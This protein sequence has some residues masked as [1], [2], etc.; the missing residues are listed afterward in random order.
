[1]TYIRK[2]DYEGAKVSIWIVKNT[3][4]SILYSSTGGGG[5]GSWTTPNAQTDKH[6]APFSSIETIKDPFGDGISISSSN[7]RRL[8][9]PTGKY[10]LDWRIG[11]FGGNSIVNYRFYFNFS[12]AGYV[13]SLSDIRWIV[14]GKQSYLQE[15]TERYEAR[16]A[17]GYYE[18][19]DSSCYI[20]CTHSRNWSSWTPGGTPT[21]NKA[22]SS[23]VFGNSTDFPYGESRLVVM[24]LE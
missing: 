16:N 5:E 2:N 12:I 18:S 20:I 4:D 14:R 7:S 3:S 10:W 9:L 13:P 1:M 6:S 15:H 8:M 23:N 19:T 17:C 11:T 21:I 24:R 22:D